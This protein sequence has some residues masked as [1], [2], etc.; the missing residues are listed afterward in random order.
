VKEFAARD[1]EAIIQAVV[2]LLYEVNLQYL[3]HKVLLV[4]TPVEIQVERLMK[5]DGI[6]REMAVNILSSQLPLEEKRS[7]ADFIVDNS[8]SLEET[9]K[10]VQGIWEKLKKFPKGKRKS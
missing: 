10:Q 8:G 5:R 6:S 7:Y 4:Y 9:Q 1:P 2:P 3:F